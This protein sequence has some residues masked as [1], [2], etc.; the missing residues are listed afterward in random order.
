[1]VNILNRIKLLWRRFSPLEERLLATVRTALPPA[2]SSIF[3]AQVAAINRVQRDPCLVE[4]D[5]YHLRRGKADWAAVP[6]FPNVGEFPLAEI[7][8]TVEG[9]RFKATLTSIGGHIFDFRIHPSPK[10]IAFQAWDEEPIIR[11]LSNPLIADAPQPIKPVPQ[12]WMEFME[13]H[14]PDVTE[15]WTLF[16]GQSAWF[17]SLESGEFVVLAEREGPEFLLHRVEPA[18]VDLFYLEAHDATP[19]PIKGIAEFFQSIHR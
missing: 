3:D 15:G 9:K 5:F 8:F 4:I 17:V 10:A 16:D 14:A 11:L 7:K 13:H 12:I 2:A 6:Q 18:S 19:E 1:M